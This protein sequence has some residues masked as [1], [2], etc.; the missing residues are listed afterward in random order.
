MAKKADQSD[1]LAQ[2]VVK[3]MQEKKGL[4]IVTLD[5]RSV[6]S[7]M[8]DYFVICHGT[9]DRQVEAIADSVEEEVRKATGEKPYH[10]EGGN[11]AEWVLLDY[12]SVVVHVFSEEKRRFYG[13]EELWGDAE[14]KEYE[15]LQ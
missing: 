5:L 14:R 12:V 3:G 9:S 6:R 11:Q 4:N 15:T 2:V 10:R 8:A 1:I 13:L 7:P